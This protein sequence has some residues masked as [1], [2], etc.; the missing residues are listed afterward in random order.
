MGKYLTYKGLKKY[1]ELLI[2]KLKEVKEETPVLSFD[3]ENK[4]LVI[5]KPQKNNNEKQ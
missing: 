4:S 5:S 3:D 1:H 2:G